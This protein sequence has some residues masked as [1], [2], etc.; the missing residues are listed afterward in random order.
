VV[1]EV[2]A[3]C[4]LNTEIGFLRIADSVQACYKDSGIYFT[5]EN[6][7]STEIS[8]LSLKLEADYGLTMLVR[9]SVGPGQTL[10]QGL[11][12]GSQKLSGVRS[13]TV[14]PIVEGISGEDVCVEAAITAPLERC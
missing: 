10:Q 3:G 7:G 6:L 1:Q 13:L 5:I 8:G 12:F 14:Y 4:S 11:G 9:G 2:M